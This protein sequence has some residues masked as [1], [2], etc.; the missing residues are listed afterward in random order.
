MHLLIDLDN[1]VAEDF[2]RLH[3]I[4]W[5]N[6]DMDARFRQ[7]HL[8][9]VHDPAHHL[10]LTKLATRLTIITARPIE[11]AAQTI[12]WLTRHKVEYASLYMRP[13]GD[14]RQSVIVKEEL[15]S[16]VKRPIDWAV[17]DRADIVTMYRRYSVPASILAIHDIDWKEN[18]RGRG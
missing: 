2:W 7:Y 8:A 6:P 11:Y 17:D 3:L 15:L 4:D 13:K 10:F 16:M 1:C 14:H 12:D 18:P 9:C 5:A